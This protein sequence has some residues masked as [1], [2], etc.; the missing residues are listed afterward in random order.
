MPAPPQICGAVQVPQVTIPPQPSET[1][2]QLSPAG[3]VVI[4]T[5]PLLVELLVLDDV[6]VVIGSVSMPHAGA[7][8]ASQ[9]VA[10]VS[11]TGSVEQTGLANRQVWQLGSAAQ[12]ASSA[13][14]DACR[15]MSQDAINVFRPPHIAPLLELVDEVELLVDEVVLPEEVE[16]LVDEVELVE[17]V[18]LL[19]DDELLKKDR[20]A[21]AV[22]AVDD[23]LLLS[24]TGPHGPVGQR[25]G[26]H[27]AG[28]ELV[29]GGVT[30]P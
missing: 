28:I 19:V 5:Q 10:R 24:T 18:E 26:V 17:D 16:L 27:A 1:E 12:A 11:A 22:A 9:Q 20:R 29:A 15:H 30:Q 4:G 3:Q 8:L 6:L 13:Q 7:Q 2:P 23:E 14:H 21:A 25:S